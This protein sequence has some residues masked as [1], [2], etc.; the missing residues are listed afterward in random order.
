MKVNSGLINIYKKYLIWNRDIDKEVYFDSILL[1]L[2][3]YYLVIEFFG[4]CFGG[5]I[6]YSSEWREVEVVK[7]NFIMC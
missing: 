2:L 5:F 7:V 6:R 3:V 4:S 1:I